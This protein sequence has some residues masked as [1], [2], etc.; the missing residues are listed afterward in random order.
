MAYTNKKKVSRNQR[1]T[2][3]RKTNRRRTNFRKGTKHHKWV[4]ALDSAKNTYK[5]TKSL[6]L[7]REQMR[8][9]ALNNAQKIFGSMGE[10]M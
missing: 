5:K 6:E 7:A 2:N 9:Q 10:S 8:N 1:K 4:Y 3:K